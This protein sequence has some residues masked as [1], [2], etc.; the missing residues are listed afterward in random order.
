MRNIP[1]H[2]TKYSNPQIEGLVDFILGTENKIYPNILVRMF[3]IGEL[4][5]HISDEKVMN[6]TI[7]K[8]QEQGFLKR[9]NEHTAATLLKAD[10]AAVSETDIINV[11][12]IFLGIALQYE[13]CINKYKLPESYEKPALKA[14]IE[15]LSVSTNIDE[16]DAEMNKLGVLAYKENAQKTD[17]NTQR[18]R[19][20]KGIR[21]MA[22]LKFLHDTDEFDK[23]I[24]FFKDMVKTVPPDA[25]V[26][27]NSSK[28]AVYAGD[29]DTIWFMVGELVLD[30]TIRRIKNKSGGYYYKYKKVEFLKLGG[31][32]GIGEYIGENILNLLKPQSA[33]RVLAYAYNGAVHDKNIFHEKKYNKLRAYFADND[34][35]ICKDAKDLYEEVKKNKRYSSGPK[36][37][38]RS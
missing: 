10:A 8:V 14:D 36:F 33:R 20:N 25:E 32:E 19:F 6:S 7:L 24:E 26:I 35:T 16:V 12:S 15:G 13:C 22:E 21:E 28:K 30:G 4:M 5:M 17:E 9:E 27:T 38:L 29:T 1:I 23:S 34:R 37:G 18:Q 2:S 3:N 31:I 11:V